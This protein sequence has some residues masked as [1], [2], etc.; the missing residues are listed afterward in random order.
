MVPH[1]LE[2][3]TIYGPLKW[4]IVLVASCNISFIISG[5]KIKNSIT[6]TVDKSEIE[7]SSKILALVW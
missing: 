7:L 1:L 6:K 2:N 4:K 3:S 5:K